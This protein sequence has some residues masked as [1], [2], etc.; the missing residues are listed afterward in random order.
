MKSLLGVKI[1]GLQERSP[2]LLIFADVLRVFADS[3]YVM[4][5]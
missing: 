4:Y 3:G 5:V 2:S 1:I